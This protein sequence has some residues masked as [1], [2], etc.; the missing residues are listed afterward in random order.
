MTLRQLLIDDLK[1]DEGYRRYPY[2]CSA[3]NL[4]IGYGHNLEKKGISDK[5]AEILLNDDIADA[6]MDLYKVFPDAELFSDNRRRAFV[7]MVFNLGIQGFRKF[8]KMI[9]AIKE[10]DFDKAADEM[11][12][13]LWHKQV[14][15][16]AERLAAMV[17]ND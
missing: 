9:E 6:E 8:K 14:G 5:E 11:L 3:G 10:N 7:N 12:D 1:R 4:T 2:K 15:K 16:R 13:S 17:R